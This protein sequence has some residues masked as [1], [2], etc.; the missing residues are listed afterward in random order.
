MTER[1]HDEHIHR[2]K[3]AGKDSGS[4]RIYWAWCRENLDTQSWHMKFAITGNSCS[5]YF[6]QEEDALA[7]K[8]TF[9]L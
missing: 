9:G 7:F 8:L 2:V 5:Y 3:V 4:D 1:K 6:G